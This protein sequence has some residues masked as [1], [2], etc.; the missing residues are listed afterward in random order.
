MRTDF[1]LMAIYNKPRLTFQEVCHALG[2]A[3]PTGY[4]YKSRGKFPV[5]LTGNTADI[6]DV[7][8]ALDDMRRDAV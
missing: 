1:M 7:A 8:K 4:S 5:P 6:R 2:L 3:V